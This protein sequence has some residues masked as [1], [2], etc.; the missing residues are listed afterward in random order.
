MYINPRFLSINI[1]TCGAWVELL[2]ENWECKFIRKSFGRNGVLQNRFL[3][4][5]VGRCYDVGLRSLLLPRE[6]DRLRPPVVQVELVRDELHALVLGP[7]LWLCKK[8]ADFF[9]RKKIVS[10]TQYNS[11][12]NAINR[13][14]NYWIKF[15]FAK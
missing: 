7:M 12:I 1:H 11:R 4:P 8:I 2:S 6:V 14:L 10:L 5:G 13:W 15:I 3:R 9:G